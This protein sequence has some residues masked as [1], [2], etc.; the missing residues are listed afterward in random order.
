VRGR[1][2]AP[3]ALPAGVRLDWAPL[4]WAPL[5]WAPILCGLL[6]CGLA[7]VLVGC[8]AGMTFTATRL[9][10]GFNLG[11]TAVRDPSHAAGGTLR[12]VTGQVDSLDPTRS[13]QYGLW[14]LMRLYSR[15]L[16]TYQAAPGPA[17]TTLVPDLATTLGRTTNGGRTWTYTLKPGVRFES[18]APVTAADVK[19]GIERQFAANALAGGPTWLVQLLDNPKDPYP[20]PYQDTDLYRGGLPA[21]QTPD[22]TT[23]VFHLSRPFNALDQLLAMPSASPVPRAQD[24]G[25]DYGA[26]PV[27]SGPYRFAGSYPGSGTVVL[28]RNPAWSRQT[29][30]TRTALPDR[31]ELATGL[32]PAERDARL[33]AGTADA[34]VTGA[35][36]QPGSIRRVLADPALAARA[37]NP[38][39]GNLRLVAL[40]DTVP[41]LDNVH[42]RRAVQ[43]AVDKAAVKSGLGGDYGASLA[44]TLWPRS[45]PGYPAAAPYPGG[46]GNG[47]DL[48]RARAE[49]R[50]CGRPG[51]FAT[52]IATVGSGRGLRAAEEVQRAVARVG[53]Q[54]E[55]RPFPEQVFLSSG[56]GSPTAVRNGGYGLVVVNW[57]ADFPSPAAFYPPLLDGR[58][59]RSQGNTDYAQ[60]TE[61]ALAGLTDRA[62]GTLDPVVAATLWRRIDALAMQQ[63]GYL[64]LVE[65]KAVLLTSPRLHNGYLHPVWRNVDLA[66]VSVG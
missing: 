22:P 34:D 51:G 65:D 46:P 35:G 40:P 17:G 28:V 15:Q 49:L 55:L 47:G 11:L 54:A 56:A 7:V 25:R 58:R 36:L 48:P 1:R 44:T 33:L 59:S 5:L 4:L 29:D 41:P 64:P 53:I 24:T 8:Q 66:T 18:G 38:V 23:V 63:A 30:R 27:S 19:Y 39:N 21:I 26:R 57:V 60:L 13:Y 62:A 37:D 52:R 31:V 16:V 12:L 20:G 9:P 10:V 6:L 50:A 42:C 14:D 45:M 61:R 3:G 2:H 32:S 43:Y